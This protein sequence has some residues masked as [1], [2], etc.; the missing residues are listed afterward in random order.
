MKKELDELLLFQINAEQRP[1]D[2]HEAKAQQPT[3]FSGSGF[4]EAAKNVTD[5]KEDGS[6][7]SR[8]IGPGRSTLLT[9]AEDHN[10]SLNNKTQ[11]D[12]K[13]KGNEDPKIPT[14][15]LDEEAIVGQIKKKKKAYKSAFIVLK[16]AKTEE[17]YLQELVSRLRLNLTSAFNAWWEDR[18]NAIAAQ[19]EPPQTREELRG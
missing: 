14:P 18:T 2:E 16:N 12:T 9:T 19:V 7:I 4:D 5:K 10:Q 11:E 6:R 15:T 8:Q 1:A 13:P 3:R 17:M